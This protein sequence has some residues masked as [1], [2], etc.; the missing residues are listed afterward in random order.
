MATLIVAG[1]LLTVTLNCG[2]GR[3]ALASCASFVLASSLDTVTYALLGDRAQLVRVNGSNVVS[4]AADSVVFPWIA[5]GGFAPWVTLAQFGAKA[6][7][8][9]LW[10]LVLM[11]QSEEAP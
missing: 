7:G 10:S 6:L 2:A 1:S 5:F 11:T 4:A 8:G 3:I 9:W